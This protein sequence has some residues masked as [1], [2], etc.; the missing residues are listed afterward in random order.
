VR[1][2]IVLLLS[3]LAGGWMLQ[4]G[5][6]ADERAPADSRVF[7]QV[8]SLVQ[9]AYVDPV[10]DV[11]LYEAAIEGVL[12][13]L[14]DP[15]SAYLEAPDAEN[16][17][18]RTEGEYGGVGLEI[19]ERDGYVTVMAPMPRT[20]GQRAGIRT[21]DRIIEVDGVSMVDQGSD[22]AVEKLRGRAGTSVDMLIERPG[23]DTPIPF[24]LE[25]AVIQVLSV[26]FATEVAPGIG[27]I[28]LQIFAESTPTEVRD[29]IERLGGTGL[30][31]LILDLRANPG[32]VLDGGIAVAD[33]FLE[34]GDAVVETRGRAQ[35]QSQA[36][37][38]SQP[39]AYAELP[40]AVLV[41]ERSAS[42]SE[43]VAGALQD[44]DRALILGARTWGKG[45]VQSIFR[46]SG[47]NVL[48]LTTARWFTPA[49]R[50]IQKEREEQLSSIENGVLTVAGNVT[51]RVLEEDGERPTF[52]SMA[53]RTLVGGGGITPDV[54]IA[55]D[56]LSTSEQEAVRALF[57][58]AGA[59]STGMFD[60]VVQYV[61]EHPNLTPEFS[62]G[63][64]EL[65]AL[66][67]YLTQEA[68]LVVER[69]TFDGAGTFLAHQLESEIAQQAFED[70]GRFN[71]ML[72]YDA[73]LT[74]A[75]RAL[76]AATSPAD[77]IRTT[78]E[79]P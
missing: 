12:S 8:L 17:S 32:G 72:R 23:V 7:D 3:V 45:S 5:V 44:H 48:K 25:R 43:I 67:T 24:Q 27:Y 10:E 42:A 6:G 51:S 70:E 4:R 19:V 56:T 53:G 15:N 14:E 1:P 69:A 11:D 22:V 57:K 34:A 41:D 29:A 76:E 68:D 78:P 35:G 2:G 64:T 46:L 75:V 28:P 31:G 37:N 21:G 71:R 52:T 77:L 66:F 9:G 63:P 74:E 49:G 55:P 50:S 62:V 39:E 20:P 60:F 73:V 58:E 36:Y 40:V 79:K 59:L 38:A 54:V 47:G 61:R 18:I 13:K 65:D 16:L 30:N 26:P 33:L